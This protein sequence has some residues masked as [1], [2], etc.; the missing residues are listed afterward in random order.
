MDPL[1]LVSSTRSLCSDSIFD[2][3]IMNINIKYKYC[4][5][6]KK[7]KTWLCLIYSSSVQCIC[8]SIGSCSRAYDWRGFTIS[9]AKMVRSISI[10][11]W[12]S[13]C[14]NFFLELYGLARS[15]CVWLLLEENGIRKKKKKN[16]NFVVWWICIADFSFK[17]SIKLGHY[18]VVQPTQ[19]T[20]KLAL[21]QILLFAGHKSL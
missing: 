3:W 9:S 1:V 8:H 14:Y 18:D 16:L 11:A 5:I 21:Y 4:F 20:V 7:K 19:P 15:A 17:K 10:L 2:W 6:Q 12:I 13:P